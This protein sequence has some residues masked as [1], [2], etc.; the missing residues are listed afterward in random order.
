MNKVRRNRL[1][2]IGILKVRHWFGTICHI[3]MDESQPESTSNDV[4]NNAND[5]IFCLN[6]AGDAAYARDERNSKRHRKV[7]EEEDYKNDDTDQTSNIVHRL[8]YAELVQEHTESS[9]HNKMKASKRDLNWDAQFDAL[10]QYAKKH[11]NCNVRTG[12]TVE[13][14]EKSNVNLYAW[15]ALQRRHK[16]CGKLRKDRELKLQN[17]VDE[18]KLS[19]QGTEISARDIDDFVIHHNPSASAWDDYF[20][21]L[22]IYVDENG[23]CNVPK[24]FQVEL[25]KGS[26][27]I[28]LGLWLDEQRLFYLQDNLSYDKRFK[29]QILINEGRLHVKNSNG[30][31]GSLLDTS[32]TLADSA[33]LSNLS[34]D[35]RYQAALKYTKDNGHC[36]ID[37][38]GLSVICSDGNSCDLGLWI[39]CQRLRYKLQNLRPDRALKLQALVDSHQF[40]WM[41]A[42]ET[43]QIAAEKALKHKE[44]EELWTAWYNVLVWYGVHFGHC[45]VDS[46]ATVTLP[47]GS[48]AELGKWLARQRSAIKHCR[49]TPSRLDRMKVLVTEGKLDSA[50]AAIVHA[51]QYQ[52]QQE[53]I[54]VSSNTSSIPTTTP[55]VAMPLVTAVPQTSVG[56]TVGDDPQDMVSAVII[57]TSKATPSEIHSIQPP[58]TYSLQYEPFK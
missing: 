38:L 42:E 9:T 26:T 19:W 4:G 6:S 22:I 2:D 14:D 12:Y 29:L 33:D 17:L 56:A 21:A 58:R 35:I 55:K 28:D 7:R 45:N 50:W 44:E 15:L 40:S 53:Q 30:M 18:G 48:E 52:L 39:R 47:D 10:V 5:K 43:A 25:S 36:N 37:K 20:D 24:G 34:W 11:G 54:L 8:N 57:P 16:K 51:M 32:I 1:T 49:M 23:H 3:P 27:P 31:T 46:Q 41:S 13:L